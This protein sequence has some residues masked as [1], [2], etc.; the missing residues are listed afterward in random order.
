MKTP[1]PLCTCRNG[2]IERG[3]VEIDALS[4]ASFVKL[5]I[6]RSTIK[7]ESAGK[8]NSMTGKRGIRGKLEEEKTVS[9]VTAKLGSI[10][11]NAS[12][13]IVIW[14]THPVNDTVMPTLMPAH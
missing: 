7:A 8:V 12:L 6:D 11:L 10:L 2:R 14:D 4:R 13:A 5:S 3:E 9:D 1:L